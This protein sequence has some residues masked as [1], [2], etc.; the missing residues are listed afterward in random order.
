MRTW[1]NEWRSRS[2]EKDS[3]ERERETN[4]R[5]KVEREKNRESKSK[6]KEK[7]DSNQTFILFVSQEIPLISN[8]ET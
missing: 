1:C 7:Q 6:K 8:R 3:T 4:E 5:K 2:C